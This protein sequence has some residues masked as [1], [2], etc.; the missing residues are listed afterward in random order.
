LSPDQSNWFSNPLSDLTFTPQPRQ[1][2]DGEI[3]LSIKSASGVRS[4]EFLLESLKI[5]NKPNFKE[6]HCPLFVLYFS[7]PK[8]PISSQILS[9]FLNELH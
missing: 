6:W 7:L 9:F 5:W 8:L 3:A 2:P 1:L 4:S